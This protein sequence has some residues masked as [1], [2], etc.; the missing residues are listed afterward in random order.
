M[1]TNRHDAISDQPLISVD[2]SSNNS[3]FDLKE[4]WQYRELLFFF[5]WRE[6]AIRYK[7]TILGILWAVLQPFTTMVVFTIFFGNLAK[8]AT[9]GIPY[10]I[11]SATGLVPWTFFAQGLTSVSISMTSNA[12]MLKKIYF[13]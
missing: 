12:N 4:L 7:Q 5:S 3:I 8:I 6:I 11:F 13:P 9:N 10:P 1:S 2:A